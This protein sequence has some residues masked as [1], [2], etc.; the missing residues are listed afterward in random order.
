MSEYLKI[1]PRARVGYEMID[2]AELA[3]ISAKQ[4]NQ[5]PR[6]AFYNDPVFNNNSYYTRR[7]WYRIVLGY[8]ML[9]S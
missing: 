3:I 7:L 4:L 1:I 6:I 2:S 9:N 5:I 8:L